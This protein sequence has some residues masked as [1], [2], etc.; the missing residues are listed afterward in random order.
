MCHLTGKAESLMVSS[1]EFKIILNLVLYFNMYNDS[2]VMITFKKKNT[3]LNKSYWIIIK[4]LTHFKDSI[5]S[6]IKILH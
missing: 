3:G 2:T 6:R 1:N 4:R 5:C